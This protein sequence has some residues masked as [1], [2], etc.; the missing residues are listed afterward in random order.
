[1]FLMN[2][3]DVSEVIPFVLSEI[4][5]DFNLLECKVLAGV[6]LIPLF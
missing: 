3:I 5:H 4:I 6:I 1:M 2:N